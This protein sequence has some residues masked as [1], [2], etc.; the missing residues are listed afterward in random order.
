MTRAH[1]L[2][3]RA[4]TIAHQ[5]RGKRTAPHWATIARVLEDGAVDPQ[6]DWRGMTAAANRAAQHYLRQ[7]IAAPDDA[8]RSALVGDLISIAR[9]IARKAQIWGGVPTAIEDYLNSMADAQ[10]LPTHK[11]AA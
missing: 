10:G 11:D 1:H 6:L 4:R 9:I 5:H 7:H 8:A 2:A 3:E